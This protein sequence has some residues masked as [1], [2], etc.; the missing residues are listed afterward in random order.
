MEAKFSS[1]TLVDFQRTTRCYI[2]K[3][4]IL[5]NNRCENLI[6]YIILILFNDCV[7]LHML[8]SIK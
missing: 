1:E 7:Q 2:L 5:Y 6:S 8:Y 3:Y 4:R